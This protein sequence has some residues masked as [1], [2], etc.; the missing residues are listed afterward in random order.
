M[1]V[2]VYPGMLFV[3]IA[4]ITW[5]WRLLRP[6]PNKLSHFTHWSDSKVRD[7]LTAEKQKATS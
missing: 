6:E 5:Q 7:V 4:I 3:Y 2:F 1:H